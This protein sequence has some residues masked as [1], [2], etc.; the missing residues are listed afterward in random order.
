MGSEMA[1]WDGAIDALEK[2]DEVVALCHVN[3]DGDALGSLLGA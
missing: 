2:A 1:D 3:P